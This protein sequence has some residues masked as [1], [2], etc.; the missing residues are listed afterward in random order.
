VRPHYHRWLD[1]V[2][3]RTPLGLSE[4]DPAAQNWHEFVDVHDFL[5][6]P[7][8]RLAP[9]ESQFLRDRILTIRDYGRR[10]LLK[11]LAAGVHLKDEAFLW[12]VPFVAAGRAALSDAAEHARRLSVAIEGAML[13]YNLGCARLRENPTWVADWRAR[14]E[15]WWAEHPSAHWRAWDLR[16]FWALVSTLPG[17]PHAREM[18]QPFVDAWVGELRRPAPDMPA[19]RDSARRVVERRERQFKLGRARLLNGPALR[20]WDGKIGVGAA[21]MRFRWPQAARILRDLDAPPTP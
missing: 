1:S 2:G 17:G 14:A 16:A 7:E 11:D 19:D 5:D 8:L 13:A 18:T 9:A 12:D 3:A 10:P 6:R 4:D 20:S 21:P 15:D